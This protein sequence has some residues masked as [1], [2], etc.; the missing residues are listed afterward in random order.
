MAW[1]S[2][3]FVASARIAEFSAGRHTGCGSTQNLTVVSLNPRWERL[4]YARNQENVDFRLVN[5]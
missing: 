5:P 4:I 3:A 2:S 1:V